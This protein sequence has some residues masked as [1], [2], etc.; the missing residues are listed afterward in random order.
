M[1]FLITGGNGQLGSE[2][3]VISKK[4]KDHQWFFSDIDQFNLADLEKI[5]FYLKKENISKHGY[6]QKKLMDGDITEKEKI[7]LKKS[8]LEKFEALDDQEK[9]LL[10]SL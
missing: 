4:N 10:K 8:L 3:R 7:E 6:L 5:N 9:E 1:K 2:L